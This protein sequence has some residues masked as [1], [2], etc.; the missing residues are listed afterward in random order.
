MNVLTYQV[1]TNVDVKRDITEMVL[2]RVNS[3][4]N[5]S[6]AF[7]T[8]TK[9]GPPVSTHIRVSSAAVRMA[10]KATGVHAKISTNV[11]VDST[12]VRKLMAGCVLTLMAP[13]SVFAKQV[14][15]ELAKIAPISMSVQQALINV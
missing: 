2:N 14:L 6:K 4:M 11:I 3:P 9:L 7:T 5:A 10:L 1:D 12:I 8:V 13:S 15:L